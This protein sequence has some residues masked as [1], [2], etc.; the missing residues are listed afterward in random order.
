MNIVGAFVSVDSLEILTNP[1]DIVLVANTIASEHVS[2]CS[3][4][5]E[6]FS[7]VV[8]LDN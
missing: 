5:I 7:T 1:H 3:G 6:S 4:N 8:S 2:G